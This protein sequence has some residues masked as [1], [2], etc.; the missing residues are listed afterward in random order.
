MHAAQALLNLSVLVLLLLDERIA[1]LCHATVVAIAFG[2]LCL[3]V[4]LLDVDLVL[5]NFVDEFFL[6]F[7]LGVIVTLAILEFGNLLVQVGDAC[8][9]SVALDGGTLNL[10]L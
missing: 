8:L 3:K 5:L 1:Y 4:E 10:E 6:A 2:S 9:V 7:P